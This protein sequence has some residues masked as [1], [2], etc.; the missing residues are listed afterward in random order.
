[1]FWSA[2]VLAGVAI[3]VLLLHVYIE[4]IVRYAGPADWPTRGQ[5]G[6]TFGGLNAA[7]SGLALVGVI[8]A[9]VLQSRE[10][11]AQREELAQTTEELRLQRGQMEL[12]SKAM[13]RQAFDMT[14]F[15]LV[16]L[17][18]GIRDSLSKPPRLSSAL[19]GPE[20]LRQFNHHLRTTA[21]KASMKDATKEEKWAEVSRNVYADYWESVAPYFQTLERLLALLDSL[22]P[23]QANDYAQILRAQLAPSEQAALFHHGLSEK[24]RHVGDA[25]LRHGL[26]NDIDPGLIRGGMNEWYSVLDAPTGTM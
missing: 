7:F 8:V 1:M 11:E 15:R 13:S 20:V 19:S 6:D 21:S 22:P 9:V 4:L 18:R 10:L 26:F 17:I 12:Q 24:G 14:F 2:I 5:I 25:M 3:V 16:D 23:D